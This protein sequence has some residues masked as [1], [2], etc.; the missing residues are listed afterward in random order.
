MDKLSL[1]KV[2]GIPESFGVV[3]LTF[4]FILLLSPY[5]SGTDFGLF[6]IPTFTIPAN[7]KLKIIGPIIFLLSSFSFAPIFTLNSAS[8]PNSDYNLSSDFSLNTNPKG[9]WSYGFMNNDESPNP[10]TFKIYTFH[11]SYYDFFANKPIEG[12]YT[13][14]NPLPEGTGQGR[15]S[16]LE[17][18]KNITEQKVRLSAPNQVSLHPGFNGYYSAVRWTV[19]ESR[20]YLVT[21]E[22]VGL[23]TKPTSTDIY[24]IHNDE[25]IYSDY[26]NDYQRPHQFSR[27]LSLTQ[28]DTIDFIVGWGKDKTIWGDTTGLRVEVVRPN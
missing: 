15:D 28:G 4:S 24:V 17:I 25:K 23:D 27:N 20:N 16:G 14:R 5:F 2:I 6:K 19:P 22:F 11:G 13:W 26:V 18:T 7:K 8:N 1:L 21:A 10:S 9:T 3:L 12:L